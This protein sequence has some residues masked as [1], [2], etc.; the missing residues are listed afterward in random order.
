MCLL[1]SSPVTNTYTQLHHQSCLETLLRRTDVTSGTVWIYSCDIWMFFHRRL[2]KSNL[3][4]TKRKTS[5]VIRFPFDRRL[6]YR[7]ARSGISR[8]HGW[9]VDPSDLR[10]LF[11]DGHRAGAD[12]Q[13]YCPHGSRF[14]ALAAC[15][16]L[17]R[18]FWTIPL[19]CR[20]V[21]VNRTERNASRCAQAR[22]RYR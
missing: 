3:I 10:T 7:I 17:S 5:R 2:I 20:R 4:R 9:I 18:A 12:K 8:Y 6:Q 21:E 13:N 15:S 14:A 19:V 22:F 11:E 16:P 1:A